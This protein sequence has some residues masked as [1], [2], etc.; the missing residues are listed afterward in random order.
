[1]GIRRRFGGSFLSGFRL[2]NTLTDARQPFTCLTSSLRGHQSTAAPLGDGFALNS[3]RPA[4]CFASGSSRLQRLA[5]RRL[6]LQSRS[7]INRE[8]PE[9]QQE[10]G[11][12]LAPRV[13]QLGA[14]AEVSRRYRML[15]PT[16]SSPTGDTK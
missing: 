16:R 5:G 15:I 9:R 8:F 3:C 11:V 13:R 2:V 7:G 14:V 6:P 10:F 4:A 1:M 12:I